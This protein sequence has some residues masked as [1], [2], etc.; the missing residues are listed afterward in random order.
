[1]LGGLRQK[2]SA[3]FFQFRG[4]IGLEG[5]GGS[6]WDFWASSLCWDGQCGEVSRGVPMLGHMTS[7]LHNSPRHAMPVP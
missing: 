7:V 3:L 5:D 4:D 6:G 1:M 2:E